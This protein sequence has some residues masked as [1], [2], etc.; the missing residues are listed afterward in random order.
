MDCKTDMA[1]SQVSQEADRQQL[2]LYAGQLERI[3]GGRV[4]ELVLVCCQ[5]TVRQVM[6]YE[7]A[8]R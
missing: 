4:R 2:S 5:P 1:L 8:R 6:A 7:H 3:T